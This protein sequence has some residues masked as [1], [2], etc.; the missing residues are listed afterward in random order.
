MEGAAAA[1]PSFGGA[2]GAMSTAANLYQMV[3]PQ[4]P[5]VTGNV[6]G[7]IQGVQGLY[8]GIQKATQAVTPQ[9]AKVDPQVMGRAQMGDINALPSDIRHQ[10]LAAM[11]KDIR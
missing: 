8:S 6:P 1:L 11:L 3:G 7:M 10:I 5:F 9:T 2:M 4:S